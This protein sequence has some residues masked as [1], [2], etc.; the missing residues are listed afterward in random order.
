MC[1]KLCCPRKRCTFFLMIVAMAFI[2][3]PNLGYAAEKECTASPEIGL[4]SYKLGDMTVSAHPDAVIKYNPSVKERNGNISS[5]LYTEYAYPGWIACKGGVRSY[6]DW[7]HVISIIIVPS[8]DTVTELV[9]L[10][11]KRMRSPAELVN[12]CGVYIDIMRNPS[13]PGYFLGYA[14][15]DEQ[16]FSVTCLAVCYVSFYYN[17]LLVRTAIPRLQ[18]CAW[19]EIV[20]RV[21]RAITSSTPN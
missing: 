3:V 21:M 16:P 18:L 6:Y 20:T 14:F 15:L 10:T 11:K 19:P 4:P 9:E 13:N 12:S 5:M 1:L 2:I 17:H 8:S 7:S